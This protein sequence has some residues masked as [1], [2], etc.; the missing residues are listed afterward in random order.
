[1]P[2]VY[3]YDD[4]TPVYIVRTEKPTFS[5]DEIDLT[6]EELKSIEDAEEAMADAQALLKTKLSEAFAEHKILEIRPI[7]QEAL[8]RVASQ[9]GISYQ[10]GSVQGGATRMYEHCTFSV[11]D[12][13]EVDPVVLGVTLILVNNMFNLSV[14]I[15][16]ENS[17]TIHWSL[18]KV[19]VEGFRL[20][21]AVDKA[22][23][24]LPAPSVIQG[25]LKLPPM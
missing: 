8:N 24:S 13:P 23:L 3:V 10:R 1:M 12:V 17:G 21:Q 20:R 14:D 9:V 25:I 2:K 6:D 18:D 16:G 22:L 4:E 7:V 19:I 5:T 11:F 15:T